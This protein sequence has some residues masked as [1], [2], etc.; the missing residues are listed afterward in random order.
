MEHDDI[1]NLVNSVARMAFEGIVSLSYT[2]DE[3]ERLEFAARTGQW[4][5]LPPMGA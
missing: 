4:R 1:D 5:P 3:R 2:S